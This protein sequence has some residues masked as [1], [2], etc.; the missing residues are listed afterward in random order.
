VRNTTDSAA[1]SDPGPDSWNDF[2]RR[3]W[4]RRPTVIRQPFAPALASPGEV[5]AAMI[6]ATARL[7]GE[8]H[9]FALT[10]D[11]VRAGADVE[12]WLPKKRDRT[13]ARFAERIADGD[14]ERTFA[15]F[16]PQFQLELGWDVWQR[17]RGFLS[18]LYA[19]VGVPAHRAEIDLFAG[20]YPRTRRGIHLDSAEVFCFVIEGRKRIRLWPGS[21]VP[22][23]RGYWYGLAGDRRHLNLERSRSL[24]GEPGDI[25][26]WPS[27]YWHVGESRGGAVSSLSLALYWQDSLA[28]TSGRL[29]EDEVTRLLGAENFVASLPSSVA[30]LEAPRRAVRAFARAAGTLPLTLLRRRMEHVT[31]HAFTHIPLP[32]ARG[33]LRASSIVAAHSAS[34]IFYRSV[35]GTA[36]IAANG[37]SI[38]LPRSTALRGIVDALN[39]GTPVFLAQAARGIRDTSDLRA[40]L[41]FLL[42]SGAVEIRRAGG[43]AAASRGR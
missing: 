7:Q 11:G 34:A 41:R 4:G 24:D 17:V 38:V 39:R 29:V 31:G 5:F 27:S 19:L 36:I 43:A 14:P 23:D 35:G 1:P 33:R 8:D 40:A 28:A 22:N 9:D 20:N 6:A 30:Q 3:F 25:L 42:I 10:I 18:G 16:V 32:P 13:L 12:R 37:R 26:Y 21:A 2:V 15:V